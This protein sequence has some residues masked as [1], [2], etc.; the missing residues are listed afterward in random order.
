MLRGSKLYFVFGVLL[1]LFVWFVS[2]IIINNNIILPKVDEVAQSIKGLLLDK[3]TYITIGATILR[4]IIT[5]T[6]SFI[7]TILLLFMAV[8]SQKLYMIIKPFM[9]LIKSIP[10]ASIIII[11]LIM[12]GHELSPLY[13]TSL[14]VLPLMYEA[15][16]NG[17]KSIDKAIID[18]VKTVTNMNKEVIIKLFIPMIMPF[19]LTSLLQSFGLGLKVMIMAEFI[20]QPQIGIGKVMLFEKQYLELA[21]IFAWTILVVLIVFLTEWLINKYIKKYLS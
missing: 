13:I 11:I 2:S 6:L 15:M 17:V 14:V 9:T 20:C 10:I 16:Y 1:I 21:N 8:K 5:I 12:V 18:E 3:H 19:I 4:V 7:L